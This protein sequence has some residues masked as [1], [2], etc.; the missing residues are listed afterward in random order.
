MQ[1]VDSSNATSAR[2]Q[3]SL[4]YPIRKSMLTILLRFMRSMSLC[5]LDA[6]ART[7]FQTTPSRGVSGCVEPARILLSKRITSAARSVRG[8]TA[9]TASTR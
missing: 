1:S 5:A 4:I 6:T 3:G 2:S 9:A 8:T 7:S